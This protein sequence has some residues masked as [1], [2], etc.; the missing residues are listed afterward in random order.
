VNWLNY[1]HLYYFWVVAREG[2][3]GRAAAELNVSQPTV[4]IQLR[5]LEEAFGRK[6]FDRSGRGLALT[7]AGRVAYSYAGEMFA[8]AEELRGAME[9]QPRA[10]PLR[11]SVGVLDVLPKSVV[12]KLLEPALRL[13]QPVRLICREDKADRLLADLAARRYDVVLSDAPIGTGVHVAGFNHLLGESDVTFFAS[14]KLADKLRRG[15]P[16][17]LGGAPM[18]LPTEATALRRELSL[19]LDARRIHPTVIGEFDDAATLAAFGREG[20]GV[21]PA[22]TLTEAE[23]CREYH[24]R[25]IGRTDKVKQRFYAISTEAKL[26]HPAVAAVCKAAKTR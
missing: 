13:P 5:E 3:V 15:F 10:R 2:G 18:L 26:E 25:A 8:L 11:L 23:V 4:S 24:V 17:S 9:R 7:E 16:R 19:W 1:N 21:F 12:H 22:P 6:L 20:L 14:P